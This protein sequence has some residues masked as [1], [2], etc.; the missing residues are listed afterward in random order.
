MISNYS[1]FWQ[2]TRIGAFDKELSTKSLWGILFDVHEEN[3]K[4]KKSIVNVS[5]ILK[6]LKFITGF[7]KIFIP[8]F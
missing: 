6:G 3:T 2:K 1:H 8:L 7:L 4:N 5:F